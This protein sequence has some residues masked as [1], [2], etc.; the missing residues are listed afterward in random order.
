MKNHN[1]LLLMQILVVPIVIILF[2]MPA[3]K[4]VLSL[5]ANGVFLTIALLTVLFQGRGKLWI[6]LVGW[7]FLLGS[8]APIIVLRIQSWNSDFNSSLLLGWTGAQWHSFSNINFLVMLV[9]TLFVS[10]FVKI[11]K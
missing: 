4:K 2:K 8:V 11:R 1:K 7:G 5:F 3:E 10:I 6:Q 9:V